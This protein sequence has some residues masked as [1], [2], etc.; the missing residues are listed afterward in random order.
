[1]R[2]ART[3]LPRLLGAA[4]LTAA[5]V[6]AITAFS[7][8]GFSATAAQAQYAP[9]NTSP[10][11]IS[12]T[13]TV[14]STLTAT[15]G[16][17]TSS[18]QP[19]YSYQWK[20]C[21]TKG[22]GCSNIAGATSSSYLLQAADA[23]NS[24]RVDVTAKNADGSTTATSDFRTISAAAPPT[25]TTTPAPAPTGK[26][27][28]AAAVTLPDRLTVDRIQYSPRHVVG[29]SPFVARFHVVNTKG[30]SV[31]GALVYV[32]GLPYS[33]ASNSPE[34][35]TDANGWATLTMRPTR[36]MPMRRGT[37]LV[38]FVRARVPGQNL[39]AGASTRR[40]VQITVR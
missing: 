33:W 7:G 1:M 24:V 6:A 34:V 16:S 25:T 37:A 36:N 23:N 21:D 38:M 35:Q 22:N 9:K 32:L 19:T 8:S 2:R 5:L 20:R 26:T 10:P 40:L 18:T 17:W 14:G 29:H 12:G 15:P 13:A 31:Q 11:A 4:G 3:L 30:Q 28:A 27:I 39:L